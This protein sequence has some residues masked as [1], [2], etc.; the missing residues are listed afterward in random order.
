MLLLHLPGGSDG[1]VSA[2]NLGDPSSIPGSG[3][4]SEE[5]SGNLLQNSCQGNPMDRGVY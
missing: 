4:S 1:K 2:Y 5:E 3:R